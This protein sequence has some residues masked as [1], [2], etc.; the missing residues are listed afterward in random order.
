L[1]EYDLLNPE[2]ES[3]DIIFFDSSINKEVQEK[4]E[5]RFF[6]ILGKNK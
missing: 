6:E 1:A 3:Q 4:K 5:K 2:N